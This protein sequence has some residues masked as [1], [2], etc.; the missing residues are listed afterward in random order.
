MKVKVNI[1]N[2]GIHLPQEVLDACGDDELVAR[3]FYNRGYKNPDTI[4]QM[5]NSELYEPTG[6]CEFSDMS[7]A[8]DRIFRA[9]DNGEKICVYGDYDV[10][11]VTSTVTLVECLNFFTPKVVYHVPDRFTE[12]YGMNEDVVR[13]LAQEGVSLIIT[14]D[15]GISNIKEI[16]VAKELG[17]DV[18]LT[19][20]HTI[21]DELPPADAVLN[22]KLLEEGHR[23]RNISGCGMVYFLC[24]ALLE[25]KGLASRA[26]KFLDMLAL[27]LIADVVSLNGE[28]RYLLK[29]ALPA[30]FNTK[31]IGLRQLLMI[32]EKNGKLE[33]EEDVA[34]QIAPRINAAGRM[35]TARLP[36]EL[37]LCRDAQ[38][39]RIMA[40]KID[41]LNTERKRVQ[42]TIIDEAV[43]MVEA[44]KKNKTVLVL[45]KDFWHHGI[46]GIA[47]GRICELYR[48]PAI[49]FSLKEDG[50]TAVGSARSIEEI[51]IYELIK[52]CSGKLLKFGG[53]SQAAGL[54]IKKDDI[55]DFIAQIEL[56]A[57]NRYFIKDMINVNAD[58]ELELESIDQELYNRI[59]SA[60]PYGE[61]FEAPWFYIRNI[62][63]LSDRITEKK[64]HIMVLEDQKGKR[65]PAVK[66]FGEDESFEGRIFDIVCR[67][68]RNNYSKDAGIQLTLGYMIETFGE[69]RDLFEGEI[70]DE[71]NTS[72]ESLLKRYPEAQIFYEG[73]QAACP[74][75]NTVDRFLVRN[76]DELIFLSTPSNTDIFREVIALANPQK[77]IINFGILPNYT[78]KG[79]VLNLLGLIKHIIKNRDGRAYVDELS[80]KL[81]VEESIVKAGLK[82][83]GS[84]GMLNYTLSEDEEKVYLSEGKGVSDSRAFMAKKNLADA[85]AEKNAYQQFILKMEID[86]FKEYLK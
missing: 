80:M 43:E 79:F 23:A 41:S 85:L 31:R 63:V 2:G 19:D 83:L 37:F 9:I 65:I 3:I 74:I 40:E 73:L 20:H 55:E 35:E 4:R 76:C 44:R 25:K 59:Q 69:F 27:S 42:Q 81:C 71:R 32:A 82:Y 18:V 45:F 7:K 57:E 62:T 53:H 39:A 60:G 78:F 13:K 46:I 52:E 12:G 50:I 29:K 48:K 54:S 84:S 47:A 58:M 64:H 56:E 11:G 77:V 22:P 75:E 66:W 36:V 26:E 10:D 38:K 51:N 70:A 33:N 16:S 5:L 8:V 68:S 28:N 67:L 24:L 72:V 15:C 30:L 86:K 49:L 14:C 17:M 61:G 6:T 34:F 21:P 1:L